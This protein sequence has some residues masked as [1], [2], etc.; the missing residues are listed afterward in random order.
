MMA[1][2]AGDRCECNEADRKLALPIWF[3]ADLPLQ[4]ALAHHADDFML[5]VQDLK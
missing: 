5:E 2:S 4:S 1:S 3:M